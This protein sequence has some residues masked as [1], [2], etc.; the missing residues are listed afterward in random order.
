MIYCFFEDSAYC[1]VITSKY[2]F[3]EETQK[4]IQTPAGVATLTAAA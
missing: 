4:T 3:T 1:L 2:D